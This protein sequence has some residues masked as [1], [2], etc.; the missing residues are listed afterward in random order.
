MQIIVDPEDAW[1]LDKYTWC[2]VSNKRG[3]LSVQTSVSGTTLILARLILKP[4]PGRLVDHIDRNGLNN[5]RGNLRIA[6]NT[7]NQWNSTKVL[8]RSGLRGVSYRSSRQRWRAM[9]R[10]DG[11]RIELGLYRTPEEA[12]EAYKKASIEYHGE[13]S[14]YCTGG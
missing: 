13:F 3:G 5:S 8:G 4:P 14:P 6:T 12:H 9:I 2:T 11:F 7:Q 1:L 10:V